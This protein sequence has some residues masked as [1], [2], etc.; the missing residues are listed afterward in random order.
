MA[1]AWV[2]LWS[3]PGTAFLLCLVAGV[4][5]SSGPAN[6]HGGHRCDKPAVQFTAV[7][8]A[9][10]AFQPDPQAVVLALPAASATG[11]DLVQPARSGAETNAAVV[12][13]EPESRSAAADL[14]AA[15]DAWAQAFP[16]LE[17]YTGRAACP[18]GTGCGSCTSASCC[19]GAVLPVALTWSGTVDSDTPVAPAAR[20]AQGIYSD[21]LPR[22]PN[23]S[24][25]Q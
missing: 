20:F 19:V 10:G 5:V 6:A 15:E 22:P 9:T 24:R 13:G 1:S 4:F 16:A 7:E 3:W 8:S 21:P 23:S 25:L 12:A 2:R 11:A 17:A 18:C 14:R